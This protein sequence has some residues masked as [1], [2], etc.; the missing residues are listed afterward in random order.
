MRNPSLL[1]SF[2]SQKG[3]AADLPPPEMNPIVDTNGDTPQQ[4]TAKDLVGAAPPSEAAGGMVQWMHR[5]AK[6]K[7]EEQM[8]K[9]EKWNEVMLKKQQAKRGN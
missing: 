5:R 4:L 7:E 3:G 2:A 9:M 8:R 1:G 6:E